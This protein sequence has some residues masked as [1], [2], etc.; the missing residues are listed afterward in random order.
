RQISGEVTIAVG[1]PQLSFGGRPSGGYFSAPHDVLRLHLEDI[2]KIASQRDF[3]VESYGHRSMVGNVEVFM[4]AAPQRTANRQTQNVSR[5][6]AVFRRKC[7]VGQENA[8]S[9]VSHI[10]AVE[11]IPFNAVREHAPAAD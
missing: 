7:G 11:Q 10:T 4:D 9:V 2:R 6:V 1:R 5:D 3:Q 8:R